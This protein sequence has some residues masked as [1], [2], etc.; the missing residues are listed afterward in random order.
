MMG[1]SALCTALTASL[2]VVFIGPGCHSPQ[3]GEK[4]GTSHPF[5]HSE[6][7][8]VSPLEGEQG[9]IVALVFTSVDCPVANAMAPQLRRIFEE[10]AQRGIRCY[11]VYPRAGTTNEA[12]AAHAA[13]YDLPGIQ[14]SD[15]QHRLVQ[16]L[17]AT[18]TPEA[19]VLQF[20]GPT[21]WVIRYQGRIND[22]YSSI[23]NRRDLPS[24]HDF[25]TALRRTADGNP[26]ETPYPPAIGCFIERRN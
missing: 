5:A 24:R 17:N 19:Y 26:V 16:Q 15:P 12:M 13:A 23:G 14:V 25:H 4:V 10:S 3:A 21:T 7:T 9:E 18:R 20:T 1:A 6:S 8:H 11:L 2:L 22:L